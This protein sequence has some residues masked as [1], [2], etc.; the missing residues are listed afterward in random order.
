MCTILKVFGMTRP[1]LEPTTY[2]LQGRRSTT[3]P[4]HRLFNLYSERILRELEAMPGLV[5]GGNNIISLRLADDTAL[6]ASSEEQ[7]QVL[8]DKVVLESARKGSV[9]AQR[10][11]SA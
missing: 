4:S 3:G 6:I 1:G 7:L 2:R 9:L 5:V 8:V 10:R 11:Q